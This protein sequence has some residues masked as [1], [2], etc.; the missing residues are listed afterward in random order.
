MGGGE[1]K[2]SLTSNVSLQSTFEGMCKIH[3]HTTFH[4]HL[5]VGSYIGSYCNLSARIG[6]FTSIS[7]HVV[8]NSG[9]HPYQAPFATTSPCLFSLNP[10]HSQ[11]GS[12]FAT[13]QL[14]NELRLV[15]EEAGIAVEIGNDVWIGEGAFLVGGIKIGDGAVVF[16]HAVVTKDVPPYAVVGGVPAKVLRYRYDEK[17]IKFLLGIK[18]WNNSVD[19]FKQNWRLL[20]DI[21]KL[22]EYYKSQEL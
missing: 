7:N 1:C 11:C 9:I 5:G 22:K 21:E 2:L 20:S 3:P 13:E 14:F 8:C 17:T 15:D 10:Y 19:W 4:G 6:R 12:T 18:W 16:A